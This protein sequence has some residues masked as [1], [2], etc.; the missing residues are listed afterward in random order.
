MRY[1]LRLLIYLAI[2]GLTFSVGYVVV[3][4]Y[5]PVT[6]TPLKAIRLVEQLPTEGIAIHSRWRNLDKINPFVARAVVSTEDN[7]FLTHNGFDWEA[8]EL[9]MESNREGER[10]RGG[11]TISQQTAKNVFCLPNRTWVRKGVE[12]YYTLLIELIWG[13][14]RIMEVYLNVIE[15]GVNRYG[16]ESVARRVYDK[17]ASELNFHEA[18]MIATCLPNPRKMRIE[19]PSDYMVRRAA[20]VR[21][22]MQSTPPLDFQI[23]TPTTPFAQ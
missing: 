13:K 23:D 20:R 16:V 17:H 12:A 10:I 11:S 14:E 3:L 9:A 2:F 19:T 4:R 22:L 21:N 5:I 6:I 8:I 18:A 15:T 7:N 1:L